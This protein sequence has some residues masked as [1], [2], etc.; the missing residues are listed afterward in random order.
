MHVPGRADSDMPTFIPVIDNGD[1]EMAEVLLRAG[2]NIKT[3][4]KGHGTFDGICRIRTPLYSVCKN[5]ELHL[6]TFLLARG[7]DI[8]KK[9]APRNDRP[10]TPLHVAVRNGNQQLVNILLSTGADIDYVHA[11]QPGPVPLHIAVA[12][13]HLPLV[14]VRFKAGV[15]ASI[16]P[17][18]QSRQFKSPFLRDILT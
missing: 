15:D 2:A 7:A 5:D 13:G 3:F 10:E 17:G 11:D 12:R 16:R 1:T 6:A 4:G 9:V 8:K 18:E 14:Q